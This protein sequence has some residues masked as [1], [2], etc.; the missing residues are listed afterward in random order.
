M[1]D[2][3]L[4]SHAAA[5]V[6]ACGTANWNHGQR[7]RSTPP[8][9]CVF[10]EGSTQI[11]TTSGVVATPPSVTV[12]FLLSS[13]PQTASQPP[14]TK[15]SAPSVVCPATQDRISASSLRR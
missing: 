2:T 5:T 7:S 9:R 12:V 1:S 3:R 6:K 10:V 4:Q 14:P 8:P 13:Q 11:R 15:P